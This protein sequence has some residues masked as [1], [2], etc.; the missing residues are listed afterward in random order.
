M[1]DNQKKLEEKREAKKA[2]EEE[3]MEEFLSAGTGFDALA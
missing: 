1:K 2:E 3:F